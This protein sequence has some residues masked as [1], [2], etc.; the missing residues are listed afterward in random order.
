M[1]SKGDTNT[2][3]PAT[4]EED[5]VKILAAKLIFETYVEDET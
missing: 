2:E 3:S 1:T 5:P 4:S